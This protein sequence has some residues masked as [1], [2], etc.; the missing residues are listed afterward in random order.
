M[1]CKESASRKQEKLQENSQCA[2]LSLQFAA[3]MR[4]ASGLLQLLPLRPCKRAAQIER[5]IQNVMCIYSMCVT[6]SAYLRE[7]E[8]IALLYKHLRIGSR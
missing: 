6:A 8:M 3:S 4:T 5:N 7:C 1:K 2:F